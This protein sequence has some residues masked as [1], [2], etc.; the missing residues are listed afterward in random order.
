MG[1]PVAAQHAAILRLTDAFTP[2]R[3]RELVTDVDQASE[4]AVAAV[5]RADLELGSAIL[6]ATPE[7]LDTVDGLLLVAI[8][9]AAQ[10][11]TAQASEAARRD[12]A[13][14]TE[15]GRRSRR[16][17]IDTCVKHLAGAPEL[18]DAI[19]SLSPCYA[20]QPNVE[21]EAGSVLPTV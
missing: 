9:L 10:G 6:T 12:S 14:L 2:E 3:A 20:S 4:E 16:I 8:L 21:V 18:R 5:E 11:E 19:A 1:V 7:V 15:T 17:T 13:N